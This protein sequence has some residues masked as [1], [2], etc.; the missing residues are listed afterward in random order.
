MKTKKKT[1]NDFLIW[2]N[3]EGLLEE[4]FKVVTYIIGSRNI[5][6]KNLDANDPYTLFNFIFM[7]PK[8]ESRSDK[9]C[10]WEYIKALY[11]NWLSGTE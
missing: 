8:W 11:N 5:I 4:Y 7:D 2:L 6:L 9:N 10:D 1:L 3:N